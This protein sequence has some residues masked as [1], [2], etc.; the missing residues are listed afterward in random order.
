MESISY[1]WGKLYGAFRERDYSKFMGE[2]EPKDKDMKIF[3]TLAGP[4]SIEWYEEF[5]DYLEDPPRIRNFDRQCL[6]LQ[7]QIKGRDPKR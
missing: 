2:G 7:M 1:Y 3:I 4:K 5:V 6:H